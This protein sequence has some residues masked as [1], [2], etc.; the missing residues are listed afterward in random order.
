MRILV[1]EMIQARG[2]WVFGHIAWA[3]KVIMRW[4]HVD[5]CR[6]ET[7]KTVWNN[8]HFF[9]Y[10]I[11]SLSDEVYFCMNRFVQTFLYVFRN[12]CHLI[13]SCNFPNCNN[14][15]WFIL[16]SFFKSSYIERYGCTAFQWNIHDN[17]S[18][19]FT[20]GM[21]TLIC[22]LILILIIIINILFQNLIHLNIW[23]FSTATPLHSLRNQKAASDSE[24]E[25]DVQQMS[26]A[27]ESDNV[28]YLKLFFNNMY[29]Y[30]C[31]LVFCLTWSRN[32][33]PWRTKT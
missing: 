5:V 10:S 8:H 12:I 6:K 30:F 20:S 29:Y 3:A 22:F 1:L 15:M 31:L 13:Q 17:N 26:D 16:E 9:Q 33:D 28:C 4:E 19:F 23:C 14:L 2:L 7:E 11:R 27:E 24:S 18:L 32:D 21:R 25:E